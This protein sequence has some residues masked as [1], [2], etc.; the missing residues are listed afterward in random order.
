MHFSAITTTGMPLC[1]LKIWP[2]KS[3][4]TAGR[5]VVSQLVWAGSIS[6]IPYLCPAAV[7]FRIQLDVM[8]RLAI[9]STHPI[10]Y[11]APLFRMISE[12]ADWEVHVFFSR[13]SKQVSYDPDFQREVVWD[14]P[15]TEGYAHS[16]LDATAFSG[17]KCLDTGI[18]AFQPTALLVYGWNFPG[19]RHRHAQTSRSYSHRVPR[20]Q[21]PIDP[22]PFYWKR[23]IRKCFAL[24]LPPCGPLPSVSRNGSN[25]AYFRWSGIPKA[26]IALAPHAVDNTWLEEGPR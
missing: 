26:N 21:P 14:T 23:W 2:L 4:G 13:T 10:Q 12:E 7:R 9:L 15:L 18:E 16:H 5:R 11:N 3:K 19:H 20:R 17:K 22:M 24:G 8:I 1:E 6:C 25:T